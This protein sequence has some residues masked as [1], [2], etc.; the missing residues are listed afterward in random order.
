MTK[1][2][3]S[4]VCLL[5]SMMACRSQEIKENGSVEP[6]K[7]INKEIS[8]LLQEEEKVE[9]IRK[10]A[11]KTNYS[12]NFQSIIVH[13]EEQLNLPKDFFNELPLTMKANMEHMFKKVMVYELINNNE[14]SIYQPISANIHLSSA[15]AD[16]TNLIKVSTE[17]IFK[18]F[19]SKNIIRKTEINDT[20]YII[21]SSLSP[22]KWNVLSE[23]K[24]IGEVMCRNATIVRN[25]NYLITAW[26]AV[27]IPINDGPS[28]YW[29]LPGL[30]ISLETPEKNYTVV[31]IN[32][33]DEN[34]S[35]KAPN[36]GKK[37]SQNEYEQIVDKLKKN[38]I[39]RKEVN[40]LMK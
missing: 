29:G 23:Q 20:D 27:D 14:Q 19:L 13:Y 4:F 2:I 36:Q 32:Y 17:T 15:D 7:K 35:I 3:L 38:P 33:N 24:K 8:N 28:N 39:I 11:M 6:I 30:I 12:T 37:I 1:I 5:W 26:Y 18:E 10:E 31:K 25:D 40:E 21:Q 22:L 34:T 16:E 9:T